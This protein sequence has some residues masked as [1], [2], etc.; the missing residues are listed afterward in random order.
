[1]DKLIIPISNIVAT[2]RCNLR[3]RLCSTQASYYRT[4]YHPTLDLLKKQA[5]CFFSV[6]DYVGRFII[7]GGEVMLRSDLN[8]WVEYLSKFSS[9]IGKLELN[10]NGTIVPT[11]KLIASLSEYPGKLR[12]MV[13]NYGKDK[14]RKADLICD[15]FSSLNNAD[16]EFRNQYDGNAHFEGW[17]NYGVYNLAQI[18]KKSRE[19]AVKSW[20]TC[21]SHRMN[22]FTVM[23]DGKLHHC[24]RH[25]WLTYNKIIP[26]NSD[27]IVDF[28]DNSTSREDKRKAVAALYER[29][30][31]TSCEYCNGLQEDSTRHP[32]AQ[33]MTL[34][35]QRD[36]WRVNDEYAKQ[37]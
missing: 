29:I 16:V 8:E 3:C 1:M 13:D 18:T 15:L 9:Q 21:A 35:E 5:D 6:I 19:D 32:P 27:E 20:E 4:P 23:V 2:M 12:V 14:S 11:D 10:S 22:Y 36:I 26:D 25:I 34:D 17:L 28:F 31:F 33:Q 7:S 24:G 30:A 37:L